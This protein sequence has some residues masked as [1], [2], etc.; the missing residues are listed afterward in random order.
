MKKTKIYRVIGI[1]T[2]TSMDGIDI[3]LINTDGKEYLK[4]NQ[5]KDYQ[6]TKN[7]TR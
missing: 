2:G 7:L 4:I 1:M 5:E 3:S 6:F